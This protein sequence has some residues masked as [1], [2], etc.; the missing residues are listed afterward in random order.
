MQGLGKMLLQ[1][2]QRE[3]AQN[4]LQIICNLKS[5]HDLSGLKLHIL[6]SGTAF[7]LTVFLFRLFSLG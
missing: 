7:L 2:E 3:E 1:M 6:S 5:V 4:H